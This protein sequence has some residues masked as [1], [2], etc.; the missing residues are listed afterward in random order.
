MLL[1]RLFFC[2]IYSVRVRWFCRRI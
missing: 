2:K 1:F